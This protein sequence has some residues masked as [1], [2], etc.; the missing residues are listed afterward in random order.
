[1]RV[2]LP[3]AAVGVFVRVNPLDANQQPRIQRKDKAVKFNRMT[4]LAVATMTCVCLQFVPP[5]EAQV[6][7][8]VQATQVVG[9][10]LP[11]GETAAPNTPG[12]GVVIGSNFYSGDE[13]LGFRHW[14][15]ADPANPDPV[16]SGIL[17]FDANISK[18]I[19]GNAP[20]FPFCKVGQIAYDGNQTVYFAAHDQPKGQPFGLTRPG[21]YRV[22]LDG[23]TGFV[24]SMTFLAPTF[25]L[26][27]DLPTAV[28][29]GP[30]GNLY[31][32]FL[33]NG[34]IKRITNP[35]LPDPNTD[36]SNTQV[37]QS[38][39]G[40]PNG[41]PSRGLAFVGHDLYVAHDRGLAVIRNAVALAPNGAF[42]CQGGCN[43]V[44]IVDGFPDLS[45]VGITT[46]NVN[47]LYLAIDGKGVWRYTISSSAMTQI[48]IGGLDPNGAVNLFAFVG[49]H[50]NLLQLDRLGNLWIGDD[51]SDGT[52][53][54]SG[55][56][57]RISA[58]A[59]SSIP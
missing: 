48:S 22:T 50:S 55:R 25:G 54:F 3:F 24:T 7:T 12:G 57:W 31:V 18:S 52:F 36:P 6:G 29:L 56:I 39:G 1:M 8:P 42:L 40:T 32:A 43:A 45:H 5:A 46:D 2:R 21:V 38:V 23:A 51:I 15:P 44:P 33:K 9:F 17:V 10:G 53:N 14:R 28:A 27:G 11:P 59:L 47:R 19:G 4:A 37:V 41:R 49:G 35:T 34:N 26:G 20:C 58:G 30:D 16:N 13:A